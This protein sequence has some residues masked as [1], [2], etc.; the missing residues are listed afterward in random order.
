M[1]KFEL[2]SLKGHYVNPYED[3]YLCACC[4]DRISY[5]MKAKEENKTWEYA[6][7]YKLM[8]ICMCTMYIKA[9]IKSMSNTIDQESDPTFVSN[10]IDLKKCDKASGMKVKLTY[11][12]QATDEVKK[13]RKK[14]DDDLTKTEL[15]L[16][17]I[18]H[19][20]NKFILDY[21]NEEYSDVLNITSQDEYDYYSKILLMCDYDRCF[22][23]KIDWNDKELIVK[24]DNLYEFFNQ[25]FNIVL[26]YKPS[27]PNLK[28]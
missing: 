11:T 20:Y 17:C 12:S 8:I 19:A 27:R 21:I 28:N 14:H 16:A 10:L 23:E 9:N 2:F 18:H 26:D 22:K 15:G 7:K 1:N 4:V 5:I 6:N 13:S 25:Y 24:I 3:M